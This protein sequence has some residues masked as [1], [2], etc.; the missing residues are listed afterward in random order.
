METSTIRRTRF[1]LAPSDAAFVIRESGAREIVLPK[2]KTETESKTIPESYGI[3]I[4]FGL[5]FEDPRLHDLLGE[6]YKERMKPPDAA[7][8][9]TP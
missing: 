2:T 6:V 3:L 7:T 4:L 8:P 9:E 1:T 5:A